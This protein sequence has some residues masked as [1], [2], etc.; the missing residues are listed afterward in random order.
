MNS[1]GN[2]FHPYNQNIPNPYNP[3]V[4]NFYQQQPYQQNPHSHAFNYHPNY[5]PIP[6]Q[7]NVPFVNNIYVNGSAV[8]QEPLSS[9]KNPLD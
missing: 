5:Y 8:S 1:N 4:N 7:G 6:P 2:M 3:F 9:T